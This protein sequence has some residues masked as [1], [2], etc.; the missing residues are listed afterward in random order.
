LGKL[1]LFSG[2]EVCQILQRHGFHEV[3]RKGSHIIMQKQIPGCTITLPVP[4][5]KELKPVR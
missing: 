5:H 3:R 4:D 1:K 2:Q